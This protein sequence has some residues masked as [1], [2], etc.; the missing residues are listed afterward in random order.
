MPVIRHDLT[1]ICDYCG[2][3]GG[4]NVQQSKRLGTEWYVVVAAEGLGDHSPYTSLVFCRK[5][6]TRIAELASI[7]RHKTAQRLNPPPGDLLPEE[8][9]PDAS[10]AEGTA[11]P[12][13]ACIGTINS[14]FDETLPTTMKFKNPLWT[15]K[16]AIKEEEEE[17]KDDNG[18]IGG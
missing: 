6:E 9:L 12:N 18:W 11:D 13:I 17:E 5:C 7:S 15:K 4:L 2:A 16:P 8:D 14:R 3:Q 10:F 1:M